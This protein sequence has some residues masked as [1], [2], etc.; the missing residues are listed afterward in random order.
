MQIEALIA[1]RRRQ[2]G[3]TFTIRRFM[4]EF[5][6]AGLI[7]MSLLAWEIT[8]EMPEGVARMMATDR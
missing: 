3:E 7:P 2:L 4:D 8:G 1:T 6:A 5:D